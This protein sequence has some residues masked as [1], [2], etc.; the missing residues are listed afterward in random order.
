M[1]PTTR[2]TFVIT[3]L[4]APALLRGASKPGMTSRERID[5]ALRDAEVDRPPYSF[6]MHFGLERQ[7]G[8]AHAQATLDFHR[9]YRTDLVKVM[10]DFAYP[11][12]AGAWYELKPLQAPFPEQWKALE[13]IQAGLRAERPG[14]YFV[15]TIFNPWNVAEKLSSPAEVR[16]LRREQPQKLHDALLAIAKSEINHAKG[17]LRR[18]AAGVFLA[19][20]NAQEGILTREEYATFSEP[21]DRMI[22]HAAADAPLNILHLHGPKVYVDYFVKASGWKISG[23]NYSMHETGYSLRLAHHNWHTIH[24][25]LIGGI[26]QTAYRSQTVEELKDQIRL[27]RLDAGHRLIV[28]PGCSVPGGTTPEE[29][30][31]LPQAL[32]AL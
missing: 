14:P 4:G 18:G 20:A 2:R 23:L 19:V 29:L 10:S 28:A 30:R 26:D 25:A 16:R 5:A 15:E 27:A 3:A 11:R 7:G 12:P 6:W 17:A 32:G 24:G 21:Y 31:R 22:M 8:E 9:A 13:L 1:R